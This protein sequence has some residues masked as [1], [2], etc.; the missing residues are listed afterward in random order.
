MLDLPGGARRGLGGGAVEAFL[1]H[2]PGPGDADVD[3]VRMVPLDVPVWCLHGRDDTIVPPTQSQSY[4]DA[5]RAAGANAELV[6]VE[7]DHF[8]VAEPGTPAWSRQLA[9]LDTFV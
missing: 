8:A 6:E 4:V 2:P 9:L 5:A 3:P 1:G 7:G